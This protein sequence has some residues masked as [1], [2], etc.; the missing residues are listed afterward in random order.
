MKNVILYIIV[1]LLPYSI[2]AQCNAEAGSDL[3][4]CPNDINADSV[5]IGGNPTADLGI[6][7]Y[8]YK[9][10]IK[11]IQWFPGSFIIYASDI[12]DDTTA[13]NPKIIDRFAED[14]L[15][16]YLSVE[17]STGVLCTD[18]CT[19]IFSNFIHYLHLKYYT[20]NEGDSVYLN[21]GVN[22]DGG[23]GQLSYLWRPN[24]GL[25]DSTSQSGFWAKPD[26]SIKYYVSVTDSVGCKDEGEDFYYITVNHIG[27]EEN[28]LDSHV[29]IYPNPTNGYFN[30]LLESD[31]LVFRI[32]VQNALG[33]ELYESSFKERINI[34]N[35]SAGIYILELQTDKGI[36]RKKIKKE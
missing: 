18:S 11:P 14:T 10:S 19:V 1:L 26:K 17:D 28:R 4:S 9:W 15:T 6:Q 21:D 27:I 12:L 2:V 5:Q 35:F 33:Q 20:V 25:K 23:I 34:S 22:I 13:S 7:P 16:F 3:V 31:L 24:H 30:I 36:I 8:I 32:A 29:N